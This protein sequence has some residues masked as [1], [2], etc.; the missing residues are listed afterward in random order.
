VVIAMVRR[1]PLIAFFLLAFVF[2]WWPW[3]LYAAGLAASPIIGFGPFVAAILVLAFTTGRSGVLTLLRR[4]VRWRVHP[5]WYGVAL[6]LPTIISAGATV[7]NILLGARTPAPAQFAAWT[8]LVPAFFLL[9][10]VP[11]IGGAWEEPG[12]RGYAQPKLQST[13]SAVSASLAVGAVWALWHLPLMLIGKIPLTDPVF[14]VASAVVLAWVFNS[15]GGS[16]LL[17]MLTHTMNNVVSG[18]FFTAMF[19]GADWVRQGWLLGALWWI[20]AIIV[21]ILNG[22]ADLSRTYRKQALTMSEEHLATKAARPQ[23][24]PAP[25]L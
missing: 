3:P 13:R 2:S 15:T 5:L 9:L 22:R 21:V 24:A 16:V 18:G 7:L 10:L 19:S 8:G 12:W 4:M 6:L 23:P 11:G 25:G 14:I 17:V 20:A 1:H